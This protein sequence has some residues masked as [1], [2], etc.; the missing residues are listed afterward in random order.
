MKL[1]Q[2]VLVCG[3][4]LEFGGLR[5][6]PGKNADFYHSCY[7]SSGL[8]LSQTLVGSDERLLFK[9]ITENKLNLV[10]P[11]FNVDPEKLRKAKEWFKNQGPIV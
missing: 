10:D 1:Q 4:D 2:Y 9:N 6:K 3:Q 8:A 11:V 7:A 5:D